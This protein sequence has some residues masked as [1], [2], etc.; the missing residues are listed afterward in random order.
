MSSPLSLLPPR[1]RKIRDERSIDRKCRRWFGFCSP[2]HVLRDEKQELFAHVTPQPGRLFSV[3]KAIKTHRF[4][5]DRTHG[6]Q[7]QERL[8]GR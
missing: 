4:V 5:K 2:T 3:H 1:K 7:E 8:T 6:L